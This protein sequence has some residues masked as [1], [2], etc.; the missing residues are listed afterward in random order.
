[1]HAARNAINNRRTSV[2]HTDVD[3]ALPNAIAELDGSIKEQYVTAV[4]SQRAEEALYAPV[5]LACAFA[6]TDELGRFQQT[7][8][9]PPL[10][11]IVPGKNYQASTYALHM[12]AFTEPD[13]GAV[14]Q[15]FGTARNYRY[16]FSD[17]MMQGYVIL[18]GLQEG[19]LT[20]EV[21]QIFATKPQLEI[22]F[23]NEP[24]LPL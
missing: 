21:A 22:S 11:K 5:L 8:V 9:A 16:R 3:Q 12:N 7:A 14:L 19:K 20:D 6:V 4:R 24:Q 2:S 10:N 13:R 15:R 17:P 1:M 23:P 18:K